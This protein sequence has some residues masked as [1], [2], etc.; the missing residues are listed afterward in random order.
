MRQLKP[1]F[2]VGHDQPG[3]DVVAAWWD[4]EDR[5]GESQWFLGKIMS[6][7]TIDSNGMYGPMRLYDVEFDDGD[8]LMI[9]RIIG[10]FRR[11]IINS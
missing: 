7:K 4:D 11:M 6:Y 2:E 8:M 10:Y 3:Q 5:E 9:S 1:L